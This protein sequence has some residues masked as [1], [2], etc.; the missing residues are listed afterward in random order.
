MGHDRHLMVLDPTLTPLEPTI[1][2]IWIKKKMSTAATWV[3]WLL[4]RFK[5]DNQEVEMLR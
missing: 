3:A 1:S 2:H 5:W 4:T